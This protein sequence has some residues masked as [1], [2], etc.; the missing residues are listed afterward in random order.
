MQE[1]LLKENE[2]P[3]YTRGANPTVK[4]LQKKMA[5]LEHTEAALMFASGGAAVGAAVMS[6]VKSGDHIVS[7]MNPYSWTKKLIEGILGR[8]QVSHDFIDARDPQEV[9]NAVRPE[10]T[11]IYME[12]PNSWTYEMQDLEVIAKFA[13]SKGITTI[14]DNSFASPIHQ[15]PSQYGIDIIVHSATKYLSGH[16]DVVAGALCTSNKLA[17]QIFKNEYMTLGG[18]LSPFDAWLL[19]R[20][21]RT[22]PL[23]L[24]KVAQNAT[25]VAQFLENHPKVDQIYYPQ[26]SNYPQKDLA[27]KYLSG[28]GGLIT[29]E[30]ATQNV[31]EITAFCN[32]L[33]RFKLGCSWGGHE[34]LA[35]PAITTM[36]SLNYDKPNIVVNRIRLY[37][38]LESAEL[39]IKDLEQAL[40]SF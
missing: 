25:A 16:A 26:A 10:T 31:A 39:L 20:S 40:E 21:L 33:K 38:G 28:A 23:R 34:S 19:I 13:R 35:F 17:E 14:V 1:A 4:I 3:F 32:Q 6:Q 15:C 36:N 5:A 8:F 18:I 29:I 37:V 22:L 11:V 30:L 12:S 24:E 7:V 9:I 27:K 2:I